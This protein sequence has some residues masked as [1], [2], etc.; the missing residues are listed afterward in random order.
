MALAICL[1]AR[2]TTRNTHA[3]VV[4]Y[5]RSMKDDANVI[6]SYGVFILVFIYYYYFFLFCFHGSLLE[7]LF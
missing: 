2:M 5:S 6:G 4:A 3:I 1:N 7:C